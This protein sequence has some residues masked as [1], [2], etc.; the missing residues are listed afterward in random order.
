[1]SKRY[2]VTRLE[3]ISAPVPAE[4]GSYEWKPIR[5]HFDIRAFGVNAMIA[6]NRGDRVV[7]DH[8]ETQEGCLG[9]EELYLVT[10]GRARFTVDGEEIDAPAGTL[11]FVRDPG[12]RRGAI[13]I[14]PGTVVLAV[15]GQAGVAYRVSPWEGK[16]F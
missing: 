3:D 13:A 1:M 15:G 10:A 2:Q 6:P 14:D 11:I 4:P 5:H 7:D 9:H 16:Y 8:T 12:T